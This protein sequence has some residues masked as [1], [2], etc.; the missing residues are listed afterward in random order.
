MINT[1]ILYLEDEQSLG[2]I[3]RDVLVKNGFTVEWVE[4]GRKALENFKNNSYSICVVD[5]MVPGID[6]Y[7]FVKELRKIDANIPVIFL[8]ARSLTDDVIKGFEIGGND[9]LKKPFSIEELIVRINSLL[10]R[11]PKPASQTQEEFTLGKFKFN[12][13]TMELVSDS[14]T[15]LLTNLENE[16]VY[17]LILN[18]NSVVERQ[19]VLIE[20]WGDD[21]FFNARS[22]DV[23][24][25]KLRKYF[26]E[27]DTISIVNIR[28]KGYKMIVK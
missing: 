27:D 7:T 15:I 19:K 5:I 21:T 24:I 28:G 14:K 3:T 6:G 10:N 12:Y 18:K 2:K 25:T 13:A 20:L 9:Y 26:A 8:T 11:I 4:D 17:R 1:K 22:M 23:F 16:L